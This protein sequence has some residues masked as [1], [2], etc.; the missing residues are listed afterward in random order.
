[1]NLS[2]TSNNLV[3]VLMLAIIGGLL[4]Y[5]PPEVLSQYEKISKY[6]TLWTVVYFAVVGIGGG[7]FLG[8]AGGL[9][10]KLWSATLRKQLRRQQGEKS[11]SQ[12]SAEER[13]QEI[14]T[15]L[16]DVRDLQRD[17]VLE[18]SLKDRLQQ[19]AG[20]LEEKR[21]TQRLE[22]VAFGTISSGKSSLLN[23]LAGRD[24]FQTDAKGGT[25][26]QRQEIAWDD[27]DRVTLVDTPGL[28]EV[29]GAEHVAL[30]A[31]AARDADI[32][33]MV[34]DGPLRDA[35]H[36]L[37]AQL[38][39]MEKRILICVNKSDWFHER[40]LVALQAQLQ[41][42]LREIARAD[43]I[44]PVQA[45]ASQ[46]MRVRVLPNGSEV[47]EP[48]TIPAD[49]NALADRL[50]QI[51]TSD[52]RDLLL[53]NLLLQSRGLV[54]ESKQQVQAAI[55]RQAWDLVE[56]Y[57]WGAGGAAALSPLPVLDLIAGSA[58]TTKMVID[59]AR[60]YRQ[61]I[62]S[63]VA[64]RLLGELG[65]NLLAILGLSVAGPAV[66]TG[67]ASLLKTIPGAGTIAGGLLQGV[68]QALITRWIGGV[69][70][71]YFRQGMQEPNGGLTG[72][73]QREWNRVT[74][75]TELYRFVKDA[76]NKLLGRGD[77]AP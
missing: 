26:V 72:L 27:N 64:V 46:R 14:D 76:R 29:D 25:T 10:W 74:S 3:L 66:S 44:I 39:K 67:V 58:I 8:L 56:R 1:M 5:V 24:A 37:L 63:T 13:Q 7:I 50:L 69:F 19:L 16:A 51:V 38:Q 4:V 75:A 36:R 68:V 17:Q 43:D 48:I 65:K 71:T 41:G 52:G 33:L 28:G 18:P 23:A 49:I 20:R 22:I 6:G 34:V 61:E 59:L 12:L 32:V 77:D 21:Q 30:A 40:D 73:A 57:T 55:D 54:E 9:V 2:R 15:N 45:L 47:E 70:I 42:Q 31:T 60:V 11:P 62:D 53:A 35:E